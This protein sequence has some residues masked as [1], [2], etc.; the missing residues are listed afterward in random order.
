LLE[1]Y[2]KFWPHLPILK[3]IK[4]AEGAGVFVSKNMYWIGPIYHGDYSLF[5][6][7]YERAIKAADE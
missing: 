6:K 3:K 1:K 5:E 4:A 7:L 2:D